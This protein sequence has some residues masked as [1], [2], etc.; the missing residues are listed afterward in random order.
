MSSHPHF[1]RQ[2]NIVESLATLEAGKQPLSA[3]KE[4]TLD[5]FCLFF[6]FKLFIYCKDG[7]CNFKKLAQFLQN[8]NSLGIIVHKPTSTPYH[9]HTMSWFTNGTWDGSNQRNRWQKKRLTNHGNL[10]SPAAF[11]QS[12]NRDPPPPRTPSTSGGHRLMALTCSSKKQKV[13]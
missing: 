2:L 11:R 5:L 1:P 8:I 12:Q 10:I 9:T 6:F 4:G 13:L 3:L 7:H